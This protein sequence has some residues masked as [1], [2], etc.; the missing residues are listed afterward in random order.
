M[1]Q[2]AKITLTIGATLLGLVLLWVFREAL[3][4][5]GGSLAISAALR[6]L[7][8][9]LEDRGVGRGLA[10]LSWYLLILVGVVLGVLIYGLGLTNEISAATQRLPQF[11]NSLLAQWQHGTGLQQTI[12][13]GLPDFNTLFRGGTT[14]AGT[15]AIGGTVA[16]IA[17]SV[18]GDLVFIFAALSL[19]YYWLMEVTHFE[20]LWLSLLP[21]GAR[22]RARE[23]WRNSEGAVGTYIRATVVAVAMAGLLLLALYSLVGLPFATMLALIGGLVQLVP[24]LGPVLG[25]VPAVLVAL[26]VSPL[27]ALLVLAGGAAIQILAHRV[28]VRLMHAESVKVNPLLQVLLLLALADLSGFWAMVYAPALAAL[29]HALY[30]NLLA[31]NVEQQP[32]TSA[33]ELLVKRLERIQTTADPSSLELTSIL[34]RS[35]DLVQQARGMLDSGRAYDRVTSDE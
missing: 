32:E 34:R 8:Q 35:S 10:I 31:A 26:M 12:A 7:V 1:K 27:E 33:F 23:I 13:R 6:P 21:V 22:V 9:R 14:S 18:I 3:A 24:R 30:A 4:L 16:G 19:A 28:A 25:L 11:Y 5:F 29:V 15:T 2:L 17:G 20:R